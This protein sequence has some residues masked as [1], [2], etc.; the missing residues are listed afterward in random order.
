MSIY[1]KQPHIFK[2]ILQNILSLLHY[3]LKEH[4]FFENRRENEAQKSY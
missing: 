4:Y 3:D 1:L 2:F